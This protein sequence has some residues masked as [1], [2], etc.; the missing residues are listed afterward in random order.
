MATI[1]SIK[2]QI[3]N[4]EADWKGKLKKRFRWSKFKWQWGRYCYVVHP[5]EGGR[6]YSWWEWEEK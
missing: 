1:S 6:D 5:V 3:K 4:K 2:E